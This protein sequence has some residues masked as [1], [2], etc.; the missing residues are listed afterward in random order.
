MNIKWLDLAKHCKNVLSSIS[1]RKA[2]NIYI[3]IY[4]VFIYVCMFKK[5][6]KALVVAS[7]GPTH[8]ILKLD[9][10]CLKF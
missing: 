4:I 6:L 7:A 5:V 8:Y 2:Q 9:E 1:F 10:L 3:Y